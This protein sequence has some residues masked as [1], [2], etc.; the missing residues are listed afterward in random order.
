MPQDPDDLPPPSAPPE[1]DDDPQY[2]TLK[3]AA[4]LCR[5]AD[6]TLRQWRRDGLIQTHKVGR[7]KR[8]KL[9]EILVLLDGE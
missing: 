2:L 4:R 1:P 7:G 5:C 9:S 3:E 6:R 8:I